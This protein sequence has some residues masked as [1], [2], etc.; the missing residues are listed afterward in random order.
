MERFSSTSL[1]TG[2]R[3]IEVDKFQ[4]EDLKVNSFLWINFREASQKCVAFFNPNGRRK[5]KLGYEFAF[6]I[7]LF[8]ISLLFVLPPLHVQVC[9]VM[10]SF[11]VPL[12]VCCAIGL[13]VT[14]FTS[15]TLW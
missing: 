8:P 1:R 7:V 13:V 12:Q 14:V 5:G 10:L 2:K 6:A 9:N 4:S 11:G 15:Q 3:L